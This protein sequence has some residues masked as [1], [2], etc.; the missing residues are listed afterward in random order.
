LW[1]PWCSSPT[2]E[3]RRSTHARESLALCCASA[4]LLFALGKNEE[5][6][7]STSWLIVF[8][9]SGYSVGS[10][11]S[12]HPTGMWK[13]TGLA[14][15]WPSRPATHRSSRSRGTLDLGWLSLRESENP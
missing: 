9:C 8:S 15:M 5:N 4:T 10:R 14:L 12:P 2:K 3:S 1:L 6:S 13:A 7:F 11:Q